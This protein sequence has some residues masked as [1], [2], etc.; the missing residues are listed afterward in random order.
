MSRPAQAGRSSPGK[1]TGSNSNFEKAH[2]HHGLERG[3]TSDTG[4]KLSYIP[5]FPFPGWACT[6][7]ISFFPL[8]VDSGERFFFEVEQPDRAENRG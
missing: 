7:G 2:Y 1:H 5:P 4:K 8:P 3:T 6:A